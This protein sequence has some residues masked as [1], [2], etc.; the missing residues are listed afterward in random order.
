MNSEVAA[1]SAASPT[2][3]K[4]GT[5]CVCALRRAACVRKPRPLSS[6]SRAAA[7]REEALSGR[8]SSRRIVRS[9]A[10]PPLRPAGSVGDGELCLDPVSHRL[11]YSAE[12]PPKKGGKGKDK[13]AE[14]G[15]GSAEL[16][17]PQL[18]KR[19]ALRIQSLEQQLMWR[20]EKMA[21]AV[22]AQKELRERVL[23]YHADFAREKE[24]VFDVASDMTRQYKGMQEELLSR[25]N[26]LENQINEL[27]DQLEGSRLQLEETRREKAQELAR[28]DAE[29]AEQ[30]QKME[31]MA[32]EFGEMLKE[33]LD[34]A[35]CPP[36]RAPS[37]PA[38]R[39]HATRPR[40]PRARG[41]PQRRVCCARWVGESCVAR[42]CANPHPPPRLQMSERI[43]I[44][45]NSWEADTG[46]GVARRLEEFKMGV[47]TDR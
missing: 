45:N 32:V 27:K 20:E 17:T 40:R 8:S 34:K 15:E 47:S 38:R 22:A 24:E 1:P 11:E 14:A 26:L 6:R 33:T 36:P 35:R 43:E 18:L 42:S 9:L 5:I 7:G 21:H 37:A 25:I 4:P 41:A 46:A 19:A 12:M 39:A 44:A 2:I 16:D 31:D 28:K 23:Q 3:S 13:K 30:K 10:T 29:I